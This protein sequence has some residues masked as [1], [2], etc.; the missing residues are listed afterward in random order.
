MQ[1]T[2]ISFYVRPGIHGQI[3]DR[4]FL[5]GFKHCADV[6]PEPDATANPT[7]THNGYSNPYPNNTS[8][9]ATLGSGPSHR[10]AGTYVPAKGEM[11]SN[12]V[13]RIQMTDLT[14]MELSAEQHEELLETL[15]GRFGE[16]MNRHPG[17][18]WP[19]VQARLEAAPGK[20][21][22]LHEM[23]RTGGE[24]DVVGYDSATG[25]FVFY[26]CSAQSPDG[27]RSLC[28]D[29]A[30][31]DSRKADKPAG[32]SALGMAAAMGIELLT[33]QQYRALQE[34][35]DFDTATS[36][37]IVT[38]ARIRKLGGALFADRRYDHVFVYHNG[39]ESYYA[40][41]GFRG[42]LKV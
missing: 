31:W 42:S 5:A 30:A 15:K 24:P 1:D 39:A 10:T 19:A 12:T 35:G 2:M 26:D 37:W 16:N 41:R 17:L 21:W 18:D 7:I 29:R 40:A 38:P 14:K 22:S 20:L 27:R 3:I 23:E 9:Y 8:P 6:R 25:E 32:G 28:F 11:N 13:T 33:E 36:S 34:L 4:A